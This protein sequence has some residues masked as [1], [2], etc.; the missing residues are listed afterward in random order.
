QLEQAEQTFTKH[1]QQLKTIQTKR[2]YLE[3]EFLK[4]KEQLET[5]A[6]QLTNF[7]TDGL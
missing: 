4:L 1:I 6:I 7:Q 3:N 2:E 5:A